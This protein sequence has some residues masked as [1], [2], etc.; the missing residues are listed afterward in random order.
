MSHKG[1]LSFEDEE[2]FEAQIKEITFRSKDGDFAIVKLHRL[3]RSE[4]LN[5]IG[6]LASFQ[7]GEKLQISG[8][9][10]IHPRYGKQFRVSLAYPL[11]PKSLEAIREYLIHA[12]IKGIGP[13]MVDLILD[14]FA[15]DI[16]KVITEEPDK[17]LALPGMGS[18]RLAALQ[19]AVKNHGDQQ[20]TMVFLHGL[21][22]GGALAA[23]IWKRYQDQAIQKI[24]ENPYQLIRDVELFGFQRADKIAQALGWQPDSIERAKASLDHLL[25]SYQDEG[26]VCL[27]YQVLLN[28]AVRLIGSSQRCQEALDHSIQT[29]SLILE[30]NFKTASVYLPH[31]HR[32]EEEVS[33]QLK[34]MLNLKYDILSLDFNI[35]EHSSHVQLAPAQKEAVEVASRKGILLLTGGPGTGKTTTVKTLLK[36]YQ[37]H[38]LE[39]SLAAPTGRA[40]RR[41]SETTGHEA[42]TIHRLLDFNPIEQSFRRNTHH[43]IESDVVIIDETSMVDLWLFNSLLKAVD[44][45]CRLV[46]VGDAHQLPSVGAGRVYHD[47]L[48]VGIL[49]TVRLTEVFRQAQ[50]SHIIVNAYQVLQGKPFIQTNLPITQKQELSYVNTEF[51]DSINIKQSADLADAADAADAA[52]VADPQTKNREVNQKETNQD[53]PTSIN[54]TK[55]SIRSN[56]KLLDFY[57]ILVK[58]PQDALSI[59]KKLLIERIPQRFQ[60]DTQDIQ[61]LTPMY[62]GYCGADELNATIQKQINPTGSLIHKPS[63][64]RVGDKVMQLKNFY[65]K[66]VFNGDIG[67]VISKH[68]EGA[69]VDFEGRIINYP[70]VNLKMLTLAYACSIHKSQGS[71]YPAVVIP[72]LEEHWSMLQRDLLYTAMTRGQKLVVIVGQKRAIKKAITSI[73]SQ[74]RFTHLQERLQNVW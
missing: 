5:A 23:R 6:S 50:A 25:K 14:E 71:E 22:L 46:L 36:Q 51:I 3:D 11:T 30:R 73:N 74:R 34:A 54:H 57:S 58:T 7:V 40:A 13:H 17:I 44:P 29:G 64:L 41:L 49:P 43:P 16:F 37:D 38:D 2:Q 67:V 48:E 63:Q 24:Q 32:I 70:L 4:S 42:Q 59:I 47:L 27:P 28:A 18:K 39:V 66:D 60:I 69:V 68:A 20:D 55:Y 19:D 61:V 9:H 35:L 53:H 21:K 33:L 15:E 8:K 72:V 56:E 62:R 45:K 12:R 1:Q 26:H 65:E 10:N 31:M 52:D